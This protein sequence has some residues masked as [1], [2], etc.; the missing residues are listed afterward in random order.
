[1]SAFS[2]LIA[3]ALEI[4]LTDDFDPWSCGYRTLAASSFFL[5][6]VGLEP[7]GKERPAKNCPTSLLVANFFNDALSRAGSCRAVAH[8]RRLRSRFRRSVRAIR[9]SFHVIC[10]LPQVGFQFGR[11]ALTEEAIATCVPV[12]NC[13]NSS[14]RMSRRCGREMVTCRR[15]G[16]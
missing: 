1:M 13:K 2:C 12:W 14:V 5:Y 9:R 15:R 6:G 10:F 3:I 16:R 7:I 4:G 8:N 11:S